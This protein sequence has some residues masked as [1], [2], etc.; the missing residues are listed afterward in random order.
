MYHNGLDQMVGSCIDG[1][2]HG[3]VH[4]RCFGPTMGI[5]L[6][7]MMSGTSANAVAKI[8]SITITVGTIL[9]VAVIGSTITYFYA[10]VPYQAVLVFGATACAAA[11]QLA[12]ALYTLRLLRA[13]IEAQSAGTVA[14]TNQTTSINKQTVDLAAAIAALDQRAEEQIKWMG[15]HSQAL[16]SSEEARAKRAKQDAAY[17]YCERWTSSEMT[18]DRSHAREAAELRRD[19][20]KFRDLLQNSPEKRLAVGNILNFLEQM[21]LSVAESHCDEGIAKRL[22]G[23]VV[24]IM[25]Q[26]TESWVKDT[27]NMR[28]RPRLWAEVETLYAHWK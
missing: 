11:G 20:G 27:R 6:G 28:G 9:A 18:A 7:W 23:G 5:T 21:S 8:P 15:V 13:T 14:A 17:R 22:F 19:P 26:A 25:W 1:S 2:S 3:S 24:A 16:I 12:V 4:V 10:S